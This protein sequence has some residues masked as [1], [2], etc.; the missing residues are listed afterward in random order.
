MYSYIAYCNVLRQYYYAVYSYIT[1]RNL[2]QQYYYAEWGFTAS[3][4]NELS[5]TEGG[6][7]TVIAAQDTEGNSEWW[8]VEKDGEQ[9]FVP[10]TY[11]A[12][13]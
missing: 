4:P 8:L 5:L 13:V 12:K 11:L 1:Y 7:V 2:L 10:S 3:S 6:V 9:G